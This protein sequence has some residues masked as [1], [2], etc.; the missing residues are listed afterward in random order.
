M[1]LSLIAA[2]HAALYG[3]TR[4]RVGGSRRVYRDLGIVPHRNMEWAGGGSTSKAS[5]L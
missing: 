3:H 5:T 4:P 1:R 2:L